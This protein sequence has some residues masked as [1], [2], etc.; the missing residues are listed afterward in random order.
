MYGPVVTFALFPATRF[1]EALVER[2]VVSNT[3]P[4]TLVLV[5]VKWKVI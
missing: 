4:P 1:D 2:K 5:P 3:V